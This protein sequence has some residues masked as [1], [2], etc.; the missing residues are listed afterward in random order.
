MKTKDLIICSLFAA[1]TAILAQ[2]AIPFP[3]GVPLT[4]QTLAV[5][6]AGILLGA[7]KGFISQLI[8]VLMGAVGMP[9][10]AGFTGGLSIVVGSTGGFILSFPIMAYVIG[11][12]CE[13]YNDKFIVFAAMILGSIANY[14]VGTVYFSLITQLPMMES[15]MACVAPFIF[16]GIVKAILA[17]VVG[18]KL[19]QNKAIGGVLNQ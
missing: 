7:K 14:A 10:F 1:I 12:I 4:M 16:T 8:Y 19:T 13:K 17:T 5:S 3:G 6:L 18:L 9:V 2:I 15:F 11:I